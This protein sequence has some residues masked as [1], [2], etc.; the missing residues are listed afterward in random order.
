MTL[1]VLLYLYKFGEFFIDDQ[2]YNFNEQDFIA[3]G[4]E[5]KKVEVIKNN[6]NTD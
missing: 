1:G 3:L 5:I 6:P 4:K 2:Q